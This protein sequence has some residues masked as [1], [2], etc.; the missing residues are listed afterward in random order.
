MHAAVES[1]I[2]DPHRNFRVFLDGSPIHD[3]ESM[4]S[5]SALEAM[6]FPHSPIQ[7][8]MLIK[9]VRDSKLKD[10]NFSLLVMLCFG[11]SSR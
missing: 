10:F 3:E 8:N 6:L 4:L 7:L 2:A 9:A 5:R 11:W 1:L